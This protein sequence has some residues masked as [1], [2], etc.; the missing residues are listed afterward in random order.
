VRGSG[1]CP[2]ARRRGPVIAFTR[3]GPAERLTRMIIRRTRWMRTSDY[4]VLRR[5][6]PQTSAPTAMRSF[7]SSTPFIEKKI[8]RHRQGLGERPYWRGSTGGWRALAL[9]VFYPD[10]FQQSLGRM[11]DSN[12]LR[13]YRSSI[14]TGK[15]RLPSRKA[16]GAGPDHHERTATAK[17][18]SML[19]DRHPLRARAGTHGRSGE[20]SSTSGKGVYSRR[21]RGTGLSAM[22]ITGGPAAIDHR[23]ARSRIME[24]ALR[25]R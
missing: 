13:A 5:K 20:Q 3:T 22:I 11:P 19:D 16:P 12:R 15:E 23:V 10:L 4:D 25:P 21:R 17:S 8:P 7:R 18:L 9:Q 1:C 14:S 24:A 6:L 2:G